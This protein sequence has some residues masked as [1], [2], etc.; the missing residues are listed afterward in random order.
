MLILKVVKPCKLAIILLTA[1]YLKC[2]IYLKRIVK[3]F[4]L[5]LINNTINDVGGLFMKNSKEEKLLQFLCMFFLTF[6]LFYYGNVNGYADDTQ[7]ENYKSFSEKNKEANYFDGEKLTIKSEMVITPRTKKSISVNVPSAGLYFLGFHYSIQTESILPTQVELKINGKSQYQEMKNLQFKNTWIPEE[8]LSTDRY[9]NEMSPEVD[10]L[11]D[12]QFTYLSDINGYSDFPLAVWFEQGSNELE[13]SSIE[14]ELS[15]ESIELS[16]KKDINRLNLSKDLT[17]EP[18]GNH[19]ITVEGEKNVTQNS[20]SI[21]PNGAFDDYLTPYD[22]RKRVMNFLDGMSFSNIG[23]QVTYEVDIPEDGYYYIALNY[24]QD[25]K[26]DF[27][28]F[29]NIEVNDEIPSESFLSQPI[30]YTSSFSS[31]TFKKKETDQ[32]VAIYLEKGTQ[33]LSLEITTSPTG[34][35]LSRIAEIIKEL[36]SLSLSI[37][38]LLGSS[39]D[40]NRDINLEEYLPGTMSQLESWIIELDDFEKQIQALAQVDKTPGAFTQ[41]VT[42]RKQLESLLND[43]RRLANRTNELSKDSGSAAANLATLLQESNRNNLSIDQIIFYQDSLTLKKPN[44][45]LKAINS[46]R[47]FTNSFNEQA[48]AVN[49]EKE[50]ESVQVWVNRPRQYVEL[51]QR[52]IDQD[53]TEKTGIK[54][55]LSI[56]PDANKLILS[57]A[58]GNAPDVALGV[59]YAMP[60]DMGIRD[61]LVDLSDFEGFDELIEQ[62]PSKLLTP[63]TIGEKVYAIPETMNFYVLFYRSDILESLNLEV[64]DTMNELIE[65]L[66]AL[67]QRGM[68]AFYPTATLGTSFKIFPWTMPIVYQNNGEFYTDDIL[69]SGVNQDNTVEGLRQLTNLFTIY[70]MPKDVPSFYQQFRDGSTPIGI[71]DFGNYNLILNAAPEIS[72]VWD[73]ALMPGYENQEGTV[74]RWSSGGAESSIMFESSGNKENSWEFMNW[75]L[76]SDTQKD[77]GTGLQTVYGKE[78]MW[79]TANLEAFQDLPWPTTDKDVILQQSQWINEVP[80]VLGTYMV[81]REIS[82]VYNSVVVDGKNLRKAIDLS[83]KRINRE[84]LRKLEEFGYYYDGE[85]IQQ[86]PMPVERKE[87]E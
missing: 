60:F 35:I 63:S 76:Q 12:T 58:S 32:N 9:G 2:N 85:L 86:Y 20:S 51:M 25:T 13:L 70:N 16:A 82:N 39:V 19:Q 54:V 77:F 61:A 53:F 44:V 38:N 65:M 48:Y 75:W 84:T 5:L 26:I 10:P 37:D 22:S 24:R 29:L 7:V 14:G 21:R 67:N 66:P 69:K 64:P 27:P 81:E 6:C 1:L 31:Y 42:V 78:Y 43:P 36:Q 83:T 80:R 3:R 49:V 50:D 23:D 45:F 74:E 46:V 73:I 28:V 30:P 62:Y 18:T 47:R 71:A 33:K 41:I 52:M 11:N 8:I 79:N 17:E 59:N 34:E 57:N 40:K 55:D 4:Y 72:N 56:M 87:Q 68:S 15:L